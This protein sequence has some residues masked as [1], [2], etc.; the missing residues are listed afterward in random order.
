M[1][2][3][4]F[5]AL[6]SSRTGRPELVAASPIRP[7]PS[8]PVGTSHAL[9]QLDVFG[10]TRPPSAANT[11]MRPSG[12]AAAAAG[13]VPASDPQNMASLRTSA[14]AGSATPSQAPAHGHG[15]ASIVEFRPPASVSQA[16][17]SLVSTHAHRSN[18]AGSESSPAR[19]SSTA[20]SA[21]AA[22]AAGAAADASVIT[23]AKQVSSPVSLC[24]TT[25][26]ELKALAALSSGGRLAS[27]LRS[28]LDQLPMMPAASAG[29]LS[30]PQWAGLTTS[31][32]ASPDP[33]LP[34]NAVCTFVY[35]PLL[36]AGNNSASLSMCVRVT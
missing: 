8:Y 20:G 18:G 5:G 31:P 9:S 10:G 23:P 16:Q 33:S 17:S 22:P 32:P 21:F 24:G 12:A 26:A 3:A 2:S 30:K 4:G 25:D 15:N 29:S 34:S 7:T 27:G 14:E 28:S 1:G 19:G 36:M 35:A 6:A 13:A 11:P